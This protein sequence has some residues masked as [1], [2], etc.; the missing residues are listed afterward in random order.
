VK[1][2]P[3]KLCSVT[4]L[5]YDTLD[6]GVISDAGQQLDFVQSYTIVMKKVCDD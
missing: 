3:T 5:S 6:A 4:G 1:Y 2:D